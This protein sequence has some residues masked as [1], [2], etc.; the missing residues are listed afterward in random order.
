LSE[1]SSPKRLTSRGAG[2][3]YKDSGDPGRG[4]NIIDQS[5]PE[6]EFNQKKSPSIT[7]Y[8]VE[9]KRLNTHT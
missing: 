6:K 7:S 5:F 1:P 4:K 9:E 3:L 2:A 8:G